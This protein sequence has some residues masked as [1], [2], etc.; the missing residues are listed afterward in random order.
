MSACL[1]IRKAGYRAE[2]IDV[3]DLR[4]KDGAPLYERD[5]T[6]AIHRAK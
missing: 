6:G 5:K 2:I 3:T 4:D 1:S